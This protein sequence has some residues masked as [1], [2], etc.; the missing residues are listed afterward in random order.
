MNEQLIKAYLVPII[1]SINFADIQQIWMSKFFSKLLASKP[2]EGPNRNIHDWKR[3]N[4]QHRRDL[5]SNVIGTSRRSIHNEDSLAPEEYRRKLSGSDFQ[6]FDVLDF[7]LFTSQQDT[8]AIISRSYS[9]R[10]FL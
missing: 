3:E 2:N 9:F 7:E 5:S 1:E 8:V 10:D 6:T 4:L